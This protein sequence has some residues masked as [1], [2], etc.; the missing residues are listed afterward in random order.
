MQPSLPAHPASPPSPTQSVPSSLL[1]AQGLGAGEPGGAPKA[2]RPARRGRGQA[3]RE[4]DWGMGWP[5]DLDRA[6]H[7]RSL[8]RDVRRESAS[9]GRGGGGWSWVALAGWACLV[10]ACP[11]HLGLPIKP[12]RPSKVDLLR[13]ARGLDAELVDTIYRPGRVKATR[14]ASMPSSATV[15]G[16]RVGGRTGKRAGWNLWEDTG[17]GGCREAA[18]TSGGKGCGL[19]WMGGGGMDYVQTVRH[20]SGPST[21]G[22]LTND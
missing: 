17:G 9:G 4:G 13:R 5:P 22:S 20:A 18:S 1:P 7:L 19:G 21:S 8:T 12:R 10:Q 16:R 15:C 6:P 2:C 11:E 3:G 14:F